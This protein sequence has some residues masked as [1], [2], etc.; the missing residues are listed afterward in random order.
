MTQYLL[1]AYL[2]ITTTQL[3]PIT[4]NSIFYDN[5]SWLFTFNSWLIHNLEFS[6]AFLFFDVETLCASGRSEVLWEAFQNDRL[7]LRII[8]VN[9]WNGNEA[10][11]IRN[12][13]DSSGQFKL[14][15]WWVHTICY[16]WIRFTVSMVLKQNNCRTFYSS[17]LFRKS[18][19]IFLPS[20]IYLNWKLPKNSSDN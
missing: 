10:Q 6:G 15:S 2:V 3:L 14:W 1:N 7:N 19:T 4:R 12:K 18:P 13:R 5:K 8:L 11:V 9:F 16:A 20:H 17:I